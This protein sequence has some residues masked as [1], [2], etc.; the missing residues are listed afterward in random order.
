MERDEG[1]GDGLHVG[2]SVGEAEG[3]EDV[4]GVVVER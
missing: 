1:F 4:V 2:G 3:N